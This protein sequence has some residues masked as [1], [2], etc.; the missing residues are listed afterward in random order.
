MSMSYKVDEL[1]QAQSF[2]DKESSFNN[3]QEGRYTIGDAG[4][5]IAKYIDKQ[6][7]KALLPIKEDDKMQIVAELQKQL[8]IQADP[9]TLTVDELTLRKT[10]KNLKKQFKKIFAHEYSEYSKRKEDY[11]SKLS[12]L[13][14]FKQVRD[15]IRGQLQIY[16]VKSLGITNKAK[17]KE[18]LELGMQKIATRIYKSIHEI[19]AIKAVNVD[20]K[21]VVKIIQEA[22][23]Y[24][25]QK[26][27]TTKKLKKKASSLKS[28]KKFKKSNVEKVKKPVI[29]KKSSSKKYYG[30]GA[31]PS[32]RRTADY[33][34][35]SQ[36]KAPVATN[37]PEPK[38]KKL[39]KKTVKHSHKVMFEEPYG[40]VNAPEP[41]STFDT[42]A[43]AD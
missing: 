28:L 24:V 43:Q 35:D 32:A 38:F 8:I 26:A 17:A 42:T 2:T 22:K 15:N 13:E 7:S 40:V 39:N 19:D 31:G 14:A 33:I 6:I 1:K 16:I 3:D 18:L 21:E 12:Y 29:Q 9:T 41:E 36:K 11:F 37:Q 34:K 25:A 30:N 5:E 20:K 4:I 10:K 27:K 23:R